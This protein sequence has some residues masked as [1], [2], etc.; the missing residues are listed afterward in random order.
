MW[1]F[2]LRDAAFAEKLARILQGWGMYPRV[3]FLKHVVRTG[4]LIALLSGCVGDNDRETTFSPAAPALDR[5]GLV[6]TFADEFDRFDW[7]ERFYG[8]GEKTGRWRTSYMNGNAPDLIDNRTLPDNKELQVYADRTFP[9]GAGLHPFEIID[10]GVLRIAAAPAPKALQKDIWHRQYAS[11]AI[12][13][14]GSFSQRYGVFEI[15]ARSPKGKG[16]W[17]AFWLLNQDHDYPP[18]IDVMEIVAW[19]VNSFH[20]AIKGDRYDQGT[21]VRTPDLSADYHTYTVDWGP[22]ETI[23]YLDDREVSRSRTPRDVDQPM[24]VIANLAIGGDWAQTPDEET[25]FPAY[26]DID[27]IRVWQRKEYER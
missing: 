7:D 23:F 15:R 12:S 20:T 19:D 9:K 6:R 11:G 10:G 8:V 27:W 25:K 18:E 2:A 24:Y 16:L 14:W 26:F 4:A 3:G 21:I 1:R 22:K 13:S 17:P 5:A